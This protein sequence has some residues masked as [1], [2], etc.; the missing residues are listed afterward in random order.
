MTDEKKTK[1]SEL[2]DS[3]LDAVA[4]GRAEFHKPEG[5]RCPLCG[6]FC[7]HDDEMTVV[8]IDGAR[9]R[10]CTYCAGGQKKG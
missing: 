3:E 4:G 7:F 6:T 8:V 9:I 1:N 10:V 2:D 5:G